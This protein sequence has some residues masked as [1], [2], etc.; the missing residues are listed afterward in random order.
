MKHAV[1]YSGGWDSKSFENMGVLSISALATFRTVGQ[2]PG[3]LQARPLSNSR[4]PL[5][6]KVPGPA[7]SFS[8][9]HSS[10]RVVVQETNVRKSWVTLVWPLL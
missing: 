5:W 3:R 9:P 7:L 2:S 10:K 4:Y 8:K 6:R 1:S